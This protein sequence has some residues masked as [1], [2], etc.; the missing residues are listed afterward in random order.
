MTV[1]FFALMRRPNDKSDCIKTFNTF[2]SLIEMKQLEKFGQGAS[3]CMQLTIFD[4]Q[5]LFLEPVAKM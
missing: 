1:Y 4:H 3:L 5:V 2:E